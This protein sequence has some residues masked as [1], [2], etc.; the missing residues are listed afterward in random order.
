MDKLI[1]VNRTEKD[2]NHS[3]KLG[4]LIG[5]IKETLN[6][7]ELNEPEFKALFKNLMMIMEDDVAAQKLAEIAKEKGYEVY[8]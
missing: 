3:Y 8:Y 4:W 6:S 1:V 7:G 2:Q 5:T